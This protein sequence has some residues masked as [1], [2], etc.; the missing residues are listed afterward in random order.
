MTLAADR[1]RVFR[2]LHQSGCFVMPN[3]WDLG[4]ARVL[5]QLGFRALA[6]TSSGFA[7]SCGRPDKGV[8]LDDVLEH[9]RKM[10]SGVDVP[11]NADFEGGF[12]TAPADVAKHVAAATATGI[13]GLSIED[14]TREPSAPLYDFHLAVERIHAAREA[15]DSSG[16]A[17]VLT[18]RSEGFIAGCPDVDETIRRLVAY[19]DAGADCVFAPGLRTLPYITAIVDAVA[20]APVNVLVGTDFTTV[21]TLAAA[22]VRRISVGG[23]LARTAWTAFLQAATEIAQHGTFLNLARAIP[24]V[25]MN[26]RFESE[27]ESTI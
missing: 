19:R 1:A 15:I 22:G 9:L 13:A 5:E 8:S 2:R 14:S 3:P 11:I 23:A 25:E 6:T 18:G 16:T 24:G 21:E 27:H 12:A 4:S 26:K 20:P 17:V 7:W 10:A